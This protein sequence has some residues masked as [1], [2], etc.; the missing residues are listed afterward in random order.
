MVRHRIGLI[1]LAAT[2]GVT[3]GFPAVTSQPKGFI[4][5]ANDTSSMAPAGRTG[6]AGSSVTAPVSV[7]AGLV[8]IPPAPVL[9]A[10]LRGTLAAVNQANL[11]GNY[12]VLRD[13]GAPAFREG[14]NAAELADRFRPWRENALDFAAILLLD[15]K[16]SQPP[17]ID[18]NGALRLAG[19][20][21]TAPLRIG[22]DLGF[23]PV[24][25]NWR[26]AT[27]SVDARTNEAPNA[28]DHG[29]PANSMAPASARIVQAAPA[30]RALTDS[31]NNQPPPTTP[32]ATRPVP[33][34]FNMR[35]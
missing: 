23:Q 30:A 27:I 32:P 21:P 4:S 17:A 20:F 16:L 28:K 14:Y 26:L 33:S 6:A 1:L 15:A 35:P 18:Q 31:R 34:P 2:I 29:A 3:L 12:S 19:Y 24:A 7:S 9:L 22:F 13:L 10:L 25:G 5:A 8:Q 11:T